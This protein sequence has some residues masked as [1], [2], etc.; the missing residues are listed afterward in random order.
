MGLIIFVINEEIRQT[1]Q[2][3]I[4][5]FCQKKKSFCLA[6]MSTNVDE[7]FSPI[8]TFWDFLL[9]SFPKLVLVLKWPQIA[10]TSMIAWQTHRWGKNNMR[11]QDKYL[12]VLK[13]KFK[14]WNNLWKKL[15]KCKKHKYLH[16]NYAIDVMSLKSL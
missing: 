1:D 14:Q 8:V 16:V 13:S 11:K 4:A 5:H 7:F 15:R 3:W 9:N 10:A 2:K 6:R 12:C